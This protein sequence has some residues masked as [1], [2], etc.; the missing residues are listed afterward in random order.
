M[1]NKFENLFLPL[2]FFT[3]QFSKSCPTPFSRFRSLKS[4]CLVYQPSPFPSSVFCAFFL[5][6]F[7][8]FPL[9][10]NIPP[11]GS[12][13]PWLTLLIIL[14]FR[15]LS[16]TFCPFAS[17]FYFFYSLPSENAEAR[18]RC[19]KARTAFISFSLSSAAFRQRLFVFLCSLCYARLFAGFPLLTRF[20]C[21][22]ASAH[23]GIHPYAHYGY[24]KRRVPPAALFS[25]HLFF[26]GPIFYKAH[27]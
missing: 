3:V 7:S 18:S 21:P 14:T 8:T 15:L 27:P 2:V 25:E 16:T 23:A 4:A 9:G 19:R 17:L 1:V 6:F 20:A 22:Y 24:I 11:L 5:I 26:V 12:L 10:S 13:S